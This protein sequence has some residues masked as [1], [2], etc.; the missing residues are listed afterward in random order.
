M[1][2]YQGIE[3][4]RKA[5]TISHKGY[6]YNL[7]GDRHQGGGRA[8]IQVQFTALQALI[9]HPEGMTVGQLFD[10]VYGD[11]EDGGPDR[12]PGIFNVCFNQWRKIFIGLN[13]C[14]HKEKKAG[15]IYYRLVPA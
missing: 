8:K 11:R 6:V 9:L 12:G 13:L 15:L 3:I 2:R 5:A 7:K 1:I 14:L 10:H 4:D